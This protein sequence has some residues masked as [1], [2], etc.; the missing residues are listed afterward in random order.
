MT[1][2]LNLP[3]HVAIIL[4]GNGRWAEQ[5]GLARSKGH[6]A[7]FENLKKVSTYILSRGIKVLS[8][9]AFST[10]NFKR[11]EQ[12]V[13]FLMNLF[14][15]KFNEEGD[16]F[17]K[18]NIKVVFSGRRESPLPHGVIKAIQSLEITTKNNTGGILNICINYGGKAEI[19]DVIK[20]LSKEVKEDLISLDDINEEMVNKYLYQNLGDIDL[21]IRTGGEQ[22][23][24]NFLLWQLAYSELYFSEVYFPDFDNAQFDKAL[25]AYTKRDR[26]FGGVNKKTK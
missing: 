3:N 12:E 26:R 2:L 11:S 10:E 8:V 17:N 4:D 19:V 6:L 20:K 23:I 9:F 21:L 25:L 15:S 14:I 7:G 18:N 22:R 13:N 5:R 24:S 16:F 1:E